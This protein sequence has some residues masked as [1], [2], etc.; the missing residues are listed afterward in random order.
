MSERR[1]RMARVLRPGQTDDGSF[2]RD[3]WRSIGPEAILEAAWDMVN[4]ARAMKGFDGDEPRLQRS[5]CRVAR[6]AG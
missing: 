2:D 1:V 4:E 3:F 5:V 6:K